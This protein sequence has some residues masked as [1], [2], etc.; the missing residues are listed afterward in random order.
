MSQLKLEP[1]FEQAFHEAE[2]EWELCGANEYSDTEHRQGFLYL[3]TWDLMFALF[4][5]T[6]SKK[7]FQMQAKP[8]LTAWLKAKLGGLSEVC[9]HSISLALHA[10]S[11]YLCKLTN[12]DVFM[13]HFWEYLS[14][15]HTRMGGTVKQACSV[16]LY[17]FSTY[18]E[19]DHPTLCKILKHVDIQPGEGVYPSRSFMEITFALRPFVFTYQGK[20]LETVIRNEW[21]SKTNKTNRTSKHSN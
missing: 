17:E 11:M 10:H 9:V 8:Q 6:L 2:M 19:Q 15:A 16:A 18:I 13:L 14:I 3:R 12:I 4:P 7:E 20:P 21:T 5:N 1:L